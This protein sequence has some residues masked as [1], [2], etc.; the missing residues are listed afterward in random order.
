MFWEHLSCWWV[1]IYP[2]QKILYSVHLTCRYNMLFTILTRMTWCN[3]RCISAGEECGKCQ[4]QWDHGGRSVG[5]K[6][7]ETRSEQWHVSVVRSRDDTVPHVWTKWPACA[8]PGRW[9]R[10]LSRPST[11]RSALLSGSVLM[12][13]HACSFCTRRSGT[14]TSCPWSRSTLREWTWWRLV[15]SPTNMYDLI[16]VEFH[17]INRICGMEDESWHHESNENIF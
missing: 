14:K 2:R 5:A 1:Y 13:R 8:F 7:E 4:L 15:Y 9:G 12:P 6:R 17:C 10:T 16:S 3:A 11:R